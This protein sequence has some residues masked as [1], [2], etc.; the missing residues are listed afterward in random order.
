MNF[1][2]ILIKSH[3]ILHNINKWK[4]KL[5]DLITDNFFIGGLVALTFLH[6]IV[7]SESWWP[8]YPYLIAVLFSRSIMCILDKFILYPV[9]TLGCKYFNIKSQ[10]KITFILIFIIFLIKFIIIFNGGITGFILVSMSKFD[11]F[12]YD[13]VKNMIRS[14]TSMNIVPS[15]NVTGVTNTS[16]SNVIDITNSSNSSV[17]EVTSPPRSPVASQ[18]VVPVS[19]NRLSTFRFQQPVDGIMSMTELH[20]ERSFV[21]AEHK[22]G[23]LG[24]SSSSGPTKSPFVFLDGRRNKVA[25]Y[26]EN[27]RV[28]YYNLS[29]IGKYYAPHINVWWDTNNRAW[30]ESA[31][32]HFDPTA[33]SHQTNLF[34]R[35]R[36]INDTTIRMGIE[37]MGVS[38]QF[39]DDL[40]MGLKNVNS[41]LMSHYGIWDLIALPARSNYSDERQIRYL[42]SLNGTV[43]HNTF[44]TLFNHEGSAYWS[45]TIDSLNTIKS[46]LPLDDPNRYTIDS[47]IDLLYA[48]RAQVGILEEDIRK[49]LS[50]I[51]DRYHWINPSLRAMEAY[52]ERYN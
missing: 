38:M 8:Y 40:V 49:K 11:C 45:S 1:K 16:S 23:N 18:E 37:T 29:E 9:V 52:R 50:L 36:I 48:Q 10:I 24:Y 26:V 30:V 14:S 47:I 51:S 12:Q 20:I 13:L 43:L 41:W 2:S 5:L 34:R 35:N 39:D 46:G 31:I 33:I 4:V 3:G 17:I 6:L 21:Y 42:M 25:L 44:L 28:P 27:S 32:Y 15:N 7:P 19:T 22:F